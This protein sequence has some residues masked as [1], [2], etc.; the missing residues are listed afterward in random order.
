MDCFGAGSR[1]SV[2]DKNRDSE[3]DRERGNGNVHDNADGR[4]LARSLLSCESNSE[5]NFVNYARALSVV[6]IS[7]ATPRLSLSYVGGV[8]LKW[9]A[10]VNS[11]WET[12]RDET[13]RDERCMLL[14]SAAILVDPLP[15]RNDDEINS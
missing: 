8:A 9:G 11:A 14:G 5:P 6:L 12:R 7:T 4:S 3:R 10:I 15:T 13:R 1:T 2:N